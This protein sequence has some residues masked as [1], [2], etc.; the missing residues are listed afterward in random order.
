VLSHFADSIVYF[1]CCLD[2]FYPFVVDAVWVP[3][4]CCLTFVRNIF[5]IRQ[6]IHN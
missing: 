1:G 3:S 6:E 2:A 4:W 5:I